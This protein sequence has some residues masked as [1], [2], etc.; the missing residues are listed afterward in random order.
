M[1]LDLYSFLSVNI[2]C[3]SS[4]APV[5]VNSVHTA[6]LYPKQAVW[7]LSWNLGRMV[8]HKRKKNHKICE[9]TSKHVYTM[10]CRD[11]TESCYSVLAGGEPH[12]NTASNQ[13][14]LS[15]MITDKCTVVTII[16]S[17]LTRFMIEW[18]MD[19]CMSA[20]MYMYICIFS[21]IK[22]R[23][24]LPI[25]QYIQCT[26][27][28]VARCSMLSIFQKTQYRSSLHTHLSPVPSFSIVSFV[29]LISTTSHLTLVFF[30]WP[31][32]MNYTQIHY[33]VWTGYDNNN[34]VTSQDH[35]LEK[36]IY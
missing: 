27:C 36:P 31:F 29:L 25:S 30:S 2:L 17:Q 12:V 26:I 19:N 8:S 4:S 32:S 21:L 24:N 22:I 3:V 16:K 20:W 1:S 33:P 6:S 23:M 35:F 5:T 15:T 11:M 13:G 7:V 10:N 18:I 9:N 28:F 14:K 34:V